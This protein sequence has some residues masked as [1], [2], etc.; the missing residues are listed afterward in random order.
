LQIGSKTAVVLGFAPE[1]ADDLPGEVDAW[2]FED[3]RGMSVLA[4]QRFSYGY[5][6]AQLPPQFNEDQSEPLLKVSAGDGTTDEVY[7]SLLSSIAHRHR[8][9]PLLNFVHSTILACI[10]LPFW[11]AR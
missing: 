10:V 11:P 9:E 8:T 5:M 7:A 3:A 4:S 1:Y 2:I 6:A